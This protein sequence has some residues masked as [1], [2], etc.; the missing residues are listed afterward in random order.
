[1]TQTNVHTK[2][3]AAANGK[4]GNHCLL[5]T[6]VPHWPVITTVSCERLKTVALIMK[7][8]GAGSVKHGPHY[9]QHANPNTCYPVCYSSMYCSYRIGP[10]D[11][12]WTKF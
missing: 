11:L 12:Y 5:M 7:R 8:S 6:A 3:H 4:L 2:Q 9:S 1:M 10:L